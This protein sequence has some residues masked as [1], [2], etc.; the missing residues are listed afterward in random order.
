M[1]SLCVLFL[2]VSLTVVSATEVHRIFILGTTQTISCQSSYPPPWTKIGRTH[3]DV[4]IIGVNGEKHAGWNNPR[5]SFTQ[6][7]STYSITIS[8]V[9]LSDAGKFICGSDKAIAYIVTILR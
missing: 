7:A 3:G 5:Y 4:T 9:R 6:N 1:H 2:V 8:D